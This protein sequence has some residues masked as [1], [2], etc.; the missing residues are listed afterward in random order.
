MQGG[1]STQVILGGSW[2]VISGLISKVTIVITHIKGLITPLIAAHEPQSHTA[3]LIFAERRSSPLG[4]WL[5]SQ[6]EAAHRHL[7]SYPN[8][9]ALIIRPGFGLYYTNYNNPKPLNL[10]P[11]KPMLM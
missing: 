2:V 10:K 9:R 11:P 3:R 4:P 1:G 8:I 5:P 6:E 7:R